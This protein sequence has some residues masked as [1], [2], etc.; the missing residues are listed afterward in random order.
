MN[1]SSRWPAALAGVV[2]LGLGLGVAELIA[3]LLQRT[4]TP[5]VAV[6]EAFIDI[7]PGWLKDRA[8]DWFGTN[9]KTALVV[10]M[11]V[12]LAFMSA[13]IGVLAKRDLM[14]GLAAAVTLLLVAGVAVWTRPDRE[15]IDLVPT[16]VGGILALV[17]LTWF[18][19]RLTAGTGGDAPAASD[20]AVGGERHVDRRKFLTGAVVA[21]A[22]G[23]AAGGVGR[24][25]GARRQDVEASR[26]GLADT[27]SLPSPILPGGVELDGVDAEPWQTPNKNF[28][29]IDTA[30]AKP[31]VAAEDWELR[32][33]GMVEQQEL[34]LSY[35]D[36]TNMDLEDH[37]I[38][39]NCVSNEVG[40]S[41]IGNALWTG[42]PIPRILD[43]VGITPGADAV[44]STSEDGWTAGTPIEYLTDTERPSLL[45][46]GMNGEPLPVEHGFP[47]R[48]IV[49]GLYG[50]VSA[51][52]WVVDI[53]VTRFVDFEAYWTSRGWSEKGPVKV[54]SRIDVPSPGDPLEAGTVVVAGTAWAQHRGI[55][56]VEVRIDEG[57]WQQTAL[58]AAPTTDTWVQWRF[59]WDASGG[60]H[61]LEVRATTSDGEVQ[62][63][64]G[65]PVVPSGATGWH[66]VDVAVS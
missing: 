42:V 52:K 10:G 48:M 14:L 2:S 47:V 23:A 41:L 57:E 61:R 7:V 58:A 46:I 12:V 40:G 36:L 3:G 43:M 51:T 6:G 60:E 34:R 20:A 44:K 17:I 49:P 38:T 9:D 35:H 54:A 24:W 59:E 53:E 8:I 5:V 13:A 55:D 32:V 4:S 30:L 62:T 66:A 56:A 29:L 18:A 26:E 11:C 33:H 39:L 63:G 64:T 22:I 37:W 31:L 65:Q 28:Y 19:R 27:V 45:A 25:L 50:Y 15:A 1:T 16:A 21:A